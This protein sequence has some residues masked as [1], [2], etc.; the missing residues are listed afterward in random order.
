MTTL[1]TKLLTIARDLADAEVAFAFGGA[2]ALAYCTGEPRATQDLDINIFTVPGE[3]DQALAALPSAVTI[4]TANRRDLASNGQ[5]RAWWDRTPIDLFLSTDP[6]HTI[7][8]DRV[9]TVPFANTTIPVLDCTTLA[10]FKVFFNRTKDWA[11][12]EAMADVGHLDYA[13][14]NRHI[15][16]LLGQDEPRLARLAELA[17]RRG[18]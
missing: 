14:V 6:F 7:A 18:S 15:Q 5:T 17:R 9:R 11:D 2:I 10:V 13:A 4:T 12:L 8:Q 1:S 16:N 3:A